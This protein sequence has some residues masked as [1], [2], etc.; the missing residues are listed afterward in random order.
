ML[1][2]SGCDKPDRS[3]HWY[4][5]NLHTHSYWSDGDDYPEMVMDWYK[6]Q[7]YHFVALSDHNILAE[8]EKWKL[9]PDQEIHRRGFENYLSKFG[10]ELVEFNCDSIGLHVRLKTLAEYRRLFEEADKFLI[11]SAEEITTSF[12]KKPLHLNAINVQRLIQPWPGNSVVEVLQNNIDAVLAQ[13]DSTGVPILPHINH[14]NY[15]Y[16]I[17]VDDFI[18]LRGEHF[19]EVY[20]G[21]PLVNNYGDS[22]HISTEQMWDAINIAY[23]RNGNPLLYGL[24]TDDSHNYHQFSHEHINPGRGWVMV[25]SDSLTTSAL[26]TALEAGRFYASTEVTLKTVELQDNILLIA[27]ASEPG[28]DYSIQFI[29]ATKNDSATSVLQSTTGISAR[30][31]VDSD[32]LFVRAKI[33]STKIKTNPHQVGEYEVAWTQPVVFQD[34]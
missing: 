34:K 28:I 3:S 2:L 18:Q 13:R 12:E 17:T 24:A 1:L 32:L 20:N 26:I 5:G 4:K 23:A 15:L 11:I 10:A 30:F 8:G 14:P 25:N 16:A 21:H 22:L 27:I 29:G 31:K 7:G 19:F 6:S 9:I 33:T